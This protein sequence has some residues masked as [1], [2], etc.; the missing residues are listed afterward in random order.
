MEKKIRKEKKEREKKRRKIRK[1]CI[2]VGKNK[3]YNKEENEKYG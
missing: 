2:E 3:Q 1:I